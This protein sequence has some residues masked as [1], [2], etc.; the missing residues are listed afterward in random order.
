MRFIINVKQQ[1]NFKDNEVVNFV[2][3]I[4]APFTDKEISDK[5]AEHVKF[6][7]TSKQK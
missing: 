1:E 2:N 3:E 4:Y 7:Q 5:I 6:T